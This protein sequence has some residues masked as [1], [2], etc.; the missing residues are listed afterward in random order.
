MKRRIAWAAALTA[1][2]TTGSPAA[3]ND[4]FT[5]HIEMQRPLDQQI[6]NLRAETKRLRE[7]VRDLDREIMHLKYRDAGPTWAQ[8]QALDDQL[9]ASIPFTHG[10]TPDERE[11]WDSLKDKDKKLRFFRDWNQKYIEKQRSLSEKMIRQNEAEER[12]NGLR[13]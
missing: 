11:E 4:A 12:R 13:R 6:N 3:A 5:D 10:F 1:L 8:K 9:L 2:L 7:A